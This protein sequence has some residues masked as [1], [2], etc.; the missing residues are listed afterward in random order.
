MKLVANENVPLPSVAELQ[1][2]GHDVCSISLRSPGLSDEKVLAIARQ[3]DRILITFDRDYGMLVYS[4]KLPSPPA[5]IYLRLRP[6]TPLEPANLVTPLLKLGED[7]LRGFFV[8]LERDSCRRKGPKKI[9]KK[10][11]NVAASRARNQMWII[12][13][14]NHETDLKVGDYRRRLIEHTLDPEAWERELQQRLARTDPR[15]R[16]F[17]GVVLRRLMEQRYNVVAEF[18]AGAYSID[19]V[20]NGKS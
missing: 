19:L 8:V 18:P 15:S 1:A 13:S 9:S 20:V 11:F 6:R 12:H 2:Q 7:S 16:E 14:L 4:R 17:Q 3:E 10:R 5:I